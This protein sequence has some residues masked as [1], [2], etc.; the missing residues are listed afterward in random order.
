MRGG[1]P[2]HLPSGKGEA[3]TEVTFVAFA[4]A[5]RAGEQKPVA[6]EFGRAVAHGPACVLAEASRANPGGKERLKQGHR[7]PPSELTL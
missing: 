4:A 6:K 7:G 2:A 5:V 1:I 3:E